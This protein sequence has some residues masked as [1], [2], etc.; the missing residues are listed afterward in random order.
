MFELFVNLQLPMGYENS[1]GDL[2]GESS[3]LIER[4]TEPHSDYNAKERPDV[5]RGKT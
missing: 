4:L 5:I 3:L 1:P 2:L